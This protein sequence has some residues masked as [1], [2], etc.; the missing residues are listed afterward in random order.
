MSLPA[1]QR[2]EL[3][4]WIK[5]NEGRKVIEQSRRAT[6]KNNKR[7]GGNSKKRIHGKDIR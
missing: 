5:T 7:K 1:E 4:T 6:Q 3:S 2:D